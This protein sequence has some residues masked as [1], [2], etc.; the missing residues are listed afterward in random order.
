MQL[1]HDIGARHASVFTVSVD[2]F[3]VDVVL[4]VNERCGT[5]V[6]FSSLFV[7]SLSPPHCF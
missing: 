3:P 6:C 2:L 1:L 5:L 7:F 4:R